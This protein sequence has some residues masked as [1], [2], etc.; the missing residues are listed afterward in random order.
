M[1]RDK[2][3]G[4]PEDE[5]DDVVPAF[6]H[7]EERRH[8]AAKREALSYEPTREELREAEPMAR[9]WQARVNEAR[10]ALLAAKAAE[11]VPMPAA[12]SSLADRSREWLLARLAE[13]RD[14]AQ[15]LP[16][17]VQV[18]HR[19]LEARSL[20]EVPTEEIRSQVV[21]LELAIEAAKR[22]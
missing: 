10:R 13:L 5:T 19:N 18:A 20:E 9:S 6:T 12:V 21:D 11:A 4:D 2:N 8:E 22:R 7:E 14:M 15:G 3:N 1:T 17:G 16:G